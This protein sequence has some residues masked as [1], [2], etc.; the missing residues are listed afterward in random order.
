MKHSVENPGL[1]TA[2]VR[3][4]EGK[5]AGRR[6][7]RERKII[8]SILKR[9]FNIPLETLLVKEQKEVKVTVEDWNKEQT[10]KCE[11]RLSVYCQMSC[12]Q[13]TRF[14]KK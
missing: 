12:V 2:L 5:E 11:Y 3:W 1:A 7:K 10:V 13:W 14:S 8:K 6:E 4:K 9:G